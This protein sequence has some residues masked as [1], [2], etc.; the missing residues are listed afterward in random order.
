M[1]HVK[2][3]S[4]LMPPCVF[5]SHTSS[6]Y[7]DWTADAGINLQ[8][9]TPVLLRKRAH[10]RLL[11]SDEEE[12]DNVEE[13]EEE[14]EQQQRSDEEER[15]RKKSKQKSKKAKKKSPRVSRPTQNVA[16]RFD[17][18]LKEPDG[19]F[20]PAPQ[21]QTLHQQRGL[22][23]VQTLPVDHRRRP[24]EVSVRPPNGRRGR[25]LRIGRTCQRLACTF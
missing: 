3:I 14:E 21:S 11:S 25:R 5:D 1:G 19:V 15:P 20:E 10:R 12:E 9:S 4:S 2:K 8:P 23:R 13:E 24:Q 16:K 18:D 22:L 17:E 7:S 6:D